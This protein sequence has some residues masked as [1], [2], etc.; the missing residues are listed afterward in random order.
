MANART[1]PPGVSRVLPCYPTP[2]SCPFGAVAIM[3][4]QW[5]YAMPD[6]YLLVVDD[7]DLADWELSW[8]VERVKTELPHLLD[9]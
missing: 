6:M 7:L 8:E 1:Y 4:K 5:S 9:E 2:A 3:P